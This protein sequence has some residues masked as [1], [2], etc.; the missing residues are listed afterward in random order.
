MLSKVD[1]IILKSCKN[2]VKCVSLK[3]AQTLPRLH[4]KALTHNSPSKVWLCYSAPSSS[5][6]GHAPALCG[7][8]HSMQWI[9]VL[10]GIEDLFSLLEWIFPAQLRKPR[11]LKESRG[12]YAAPVPR[13]GKET[14]SP[15]LCHDSEHTTCRAGH[16]ASGSLGRSAKSANY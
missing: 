14:T 6:P 8:L 4:Q 16:Y 10:E 5:D 3:G 15:R 12:S 11:W 1:R 13:W 7:E 2:W 9:K